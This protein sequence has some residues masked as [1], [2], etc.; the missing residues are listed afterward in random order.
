[1]K[2]TAKRAAVVGLLVPVLAALV[3]LVA[4]F[5]GADPPGGLDERLMGLTLALALL[6]APEPRRH[7]LG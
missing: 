5:A 4:A 6:G 1:M 3:L 7:A 2:V